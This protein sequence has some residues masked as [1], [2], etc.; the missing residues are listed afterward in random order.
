MIDLLLSFGIRGFWF[1]AAFVSRGCNTHLGIVTATHNPPDHGSTVMTNYCDIAMHWRSCCS[2][3]CM[4]Q[5]NACI[6]GSH[7][8][9]GS[10][11]PS[12]NRVDR[13]LPPR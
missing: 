11:P 3:S 10:G 4:L 1:F 7:A 9:P 12:R 2:K 13:A 8:G 6:L 5:A